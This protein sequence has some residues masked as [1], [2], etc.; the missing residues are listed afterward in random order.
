MGFENTLN[1]CPSILFFMVKNIFIIF[2]QIYKVYSVTNEKKQKKLIQNYRD[3]VSYAAHHDHMTPPI[4]NS[5]TLRNQMNPNSYF[6]PHTAQIAT[7]AAGGQVPLLNHPQQPFFNYQQQAAPPYYNQ[8]PTN[9]PY[10]FAQI[11]TAN[12][13]T[14]NS[15]ICP[16]RY[17]N[18]SISTLGSVANTTIF[19]ENLQTQQPNQMIKQQQQHQFYT[20]F[21]DKKDIYCSQS[22]QSSFSMP[23][24]ESMIYNT[25]GNRYQQ[26]DQNILMC[27]SPNKTA[28]K[29]KL[30][31]PAN[32]FTAKVGKALY[33]L[34][35]MSRSK[36]SLSAL[37]EQSTTTSSYESNIVAS[38]S[39]GIGLIG[40]FRQ[41]YRSS[42]LPNHPTNTNKLLK[43]SK[44]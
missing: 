27:Q 12:N 17:Q 5:G 14:S 7:A 9:N 25:H 16:N 23:V 6:M 8:G 26:Y 38:T 21:N 34:P 22:Q 39:N 40:S 11:Y 41:S 42:S 31:T 18:R 32:P 28:N 4:I 2:T 15:P 10:R 37:N 44:I 20:G 3:L 43:A 19:N 30:S 1:Q 33:G 24:T 36:S 13:V 35:F 29:N